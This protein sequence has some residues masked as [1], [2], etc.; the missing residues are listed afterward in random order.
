MRHL[1]AFSC[2]KML[3]RHPPGPRTPNKK[4]HSP[5]SQATDQTEESSRTCES[6]QSQEGGHDDLV[7]KNVVVA[8]KHN[9]EAQTRAAG[10]R[11]E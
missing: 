8:F 5:D 1:S 10:K 6:G 9:A 11:F 7:K 3:V 4:N 2:G